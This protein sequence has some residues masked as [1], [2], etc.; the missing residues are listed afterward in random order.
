M[1][2]VIPSPLHT[3][4]STRACRHAGAVSFIRARPTVGAELTTALDLFTEHARCLFVLFFDDDARVSGRARLGRRRRAG[5]ARAPDR[6]PRPRLGAGRGTARR[7]RA[8]TSG[9]STSAATATATRPP[10]RRLLV[11]RLRRRRARGRRA[12][13]PRGRRRPARGGH[14]KGGAALLLGERRE[15]GTYPRIWAYEPIIFPTDDPLPA[16]GG[17]RAGRR[18]AR[19]RRNEWP[20]TD[21]AFDGVRVEAAAR[22]ADAGVAARVRRLRAAR[23][24]RRHVRAEVPARG[25]G[26]RCTRWA[27]TTARSACLR[28]VDAAG[29][30]RVRRDVAPTS[31]PRS[32]RRS[33]T[34]SRTARSRCGRA[35]PLRPAA[36]SRRVPSSRCSGS[37]RST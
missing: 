2:C 34:G 33:P 36:G 1:A 16:A 4:R 12:P 6:L 13:R 20:S 25:R 30:R 8:G 7:A 5:A 21:E 32:A 27:R 11:A 18:G 24:R 17:L 19:K 15:P 10:T 37:R 29:A 35:R 31:R 9:R 22:R 3:A 26:A 23:S 14:S 28:E